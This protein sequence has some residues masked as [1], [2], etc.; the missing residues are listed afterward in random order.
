MP[1]LGVGE[2]GAIEAIEGA[3]AG[4]GGISLA[5][6]RTTDAQ[7]DPMPLSGRSRVLSSSPLS[8]SSDG[9][10][11]AAESARAEPP[12][13]GAGGPTGASAATAAA[14]VIVGG[15]SDSNGADCNASTPACSDETAEGNMEHCCLGE[16]GGWMA[17]EVGTEGTG[18]AACCCC[19]CCCG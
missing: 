1:R 3:L 8:A 2:G 9:S 7:P 17:E 14:A 15:M 6:R 18:P 11:N 4:G 16:A 12:A 19:C 5:G 10:E 13:A